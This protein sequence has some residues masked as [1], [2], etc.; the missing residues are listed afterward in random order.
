MV[1]LIFFAVNQ[2]ISDIYYIFDIKQLFNKG[3]LK[4]PIAILVMLIMVHS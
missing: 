3:D 2:S 4:C 1:S